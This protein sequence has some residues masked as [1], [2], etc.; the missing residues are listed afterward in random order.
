MT[1]L[2]WN[3]V[4]GGNR[5][6]NGSGYEDVDLSGGAIELNT[7]PLFWNPNWDRTDCVSDACNN[8]SVN[9]RRSDVRITQRVRF[10]RPNVA[11]LSYVVTNLSGLDHAASA[12]EFPTV[13]SS[14]GKNGTPDLDRLF[15]SAQ[16]EV[17]I[18]DYPPNDQTFRY[19]N[20]TS[21]GGW[22]TLQNQN[23]DYGVGLLYENGTS[24]F[25]A[26][27]ADDPNFNNFRALFSFAIPAYA[28]VRARSYMILGSLSTVATEAQWLRDNTPAFGSLDA[29]SGNT[30]V[31]GNVNVYGWAM[32]NKGVSQVRMIIDGG[33]P[34][35]LSYGSSRPDVCKV[36]PGYSACA[37]N[38]VGYNGSFNA[39][40]LGADP[41]GHVIEI[42]VIDSDGNA[43]II[44]RRR[45]QVQ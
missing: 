21:S 22:V 35:S 40:S 15:N 18:N 12:H 3:P 6:N 14:F 36:W 42:E 26:W 41:C 44:A 10:V 17:A 20:F 5:C 29:P 31:S 34:M 19:K 7:R 1:W 38:N 8:S 30:P 9:K 28:Q 37:N 27:Q 23:L 32:D 45:I 39:A 25:Q 11:E 24:S 43:R 33:T 4:Q 2:G 13:Y 16:Q